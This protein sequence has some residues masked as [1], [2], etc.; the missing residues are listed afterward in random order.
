[1][2][3]LETKSDTKILTLSRKFMIFK[4]IKQPH[5]FLRFEVDFS[6]PMVSRN[7]FQQ[8]HWNNIFCRM[9]GL[10]LMLSVATRTPLKNIDKIVD[11]NEFWS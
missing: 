9:Y 7:T 8:I 11:W 6:N 1:M 2:K 10:A 4:T 3:N 5:F